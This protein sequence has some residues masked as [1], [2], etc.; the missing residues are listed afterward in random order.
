M[1]AVLGYVSATVEWAE[2]KR[3]KPNLWKKYWFDKDSHNVHFIGKDNIPFHTVIFPGLLIASQQ[4]YQLPWEVSS[5]EYIQF[6]GQKFS[7]SNK[8]GIWIDEALK[9]ET[10][11]YWRYILI[12]LR[13]EQKDTDFTWEEFA[14]KVNT[15]LNDVL[16][17]FVHRTITFLISRF[18]SKIPTFQSNIESEKEIIQIQKDIVGQVKDSLSSYRLKEGLEQIVNLARNGNR[19]L[20]QR[21]PWQRIKT[22]QNAAGQSIAIAIQIVATIGI[23]LQPFLPDTSTKILQS[24][25]GGKNE[26]PSWAQLG[27]SIIVKPGTKVR[28][29]KPL[30]HKVTAENLRMRLAD[31][32][33]EQPV[34]E[35]KT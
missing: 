33:K 9:L 19:Y 26:H 10:A 6:E 5:T 31:M 29:L 7:K 12:S 35:V 24:I 23:L 32:R 28:N 22:D 8:V 16:G 2:K 13:P 11:E 3:R 18:D 27:E 25:F 20:N 14:R 15:E 17:N 4:G 30:F 21:E 1:E 34:I